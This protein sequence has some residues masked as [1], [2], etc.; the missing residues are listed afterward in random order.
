MELGKKPNLNLYFPENLPDQY[1]SAPLPPYLHFVGGKIA[2]DLPYFSSFSFFCPILSSFT[3]LLSLS[4]RFALGGGEG[5]VLL[6]PTLLYTL[7]AGLTASDLFPI[8]FTLF[9]SSSSFSVPLSSPF[10]LLSG[11]G[12]GKG[13]LPH[14]HPDPQLVGGK[15]ATDTPFFSF[16]LPQFSCPLFPLFLF[17]SISFLLSYF[18][19]GGGGWRQQPGRR[20]PFATPISFFPLFFS[21]SSSFFPFLSSFL[22]FPSLSLFFS[23]CFF[24]S[25]LSVPFVSFFFSFPPFFLFFSQGGGA[26]DPPLSFDLFSSSI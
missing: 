11:V 9:F 12:G 17:L 21:S 3:S 15:I 16:L 20:G 19:D 23:S 8:F 2:T 25:F 5:K 6:A 24:P 10:F 4:F 22:S 13:L 14:P 7:L 18:F 1:A 26:L